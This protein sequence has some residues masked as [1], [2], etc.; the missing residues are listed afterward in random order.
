MTFRETA[1]R[2]TDQR[3]DG[4]LGNLRQYAVDHNGKTFLSVLMTTPEEVLYDVFMRNTLADN[5]IPGYCEGRWINSVED[6]LDFI[7]NVINALWDD[8]CPKL[9]AWKYC[10]LPGFKTKYLQCG[11]RDPEAHIYMSY[12]NDLPRSESTYCHEE[13]L[14]WLIFDYE[15]KMVERY[16][17]DW[18][19]EWDDSLQHACRYSEYHLLA[20]EWL[21]DN[22][23]EI[24]K[25]PYFKEYR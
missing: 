14:M 6:Y 17:S 19:P 24:I 9:T 7:F 1:H 4:L 25:R 11:Y 20:I 18:I 8:A 5:L 13:H 3:I 22:E 2:E 15:Q 16:S 21:R 10:H 23:I 12:D